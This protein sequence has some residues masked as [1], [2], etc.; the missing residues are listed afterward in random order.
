[1]EITLM[2]DRKLEETLDECKACGGE[3]E[4]KVPKTYMTCPCCKGREKVRPC[5]Y[6]SGKGVK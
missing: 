6:C 2:N 5:R 4:M 1:M 3:G